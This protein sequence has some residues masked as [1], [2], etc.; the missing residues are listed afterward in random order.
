MPIRKPRKEHW[1]T[2]LSATWWPISKRLRK[3]RVTLLTS[4]GVGRLRIL[5]LMTSLKPSRRKGEMADLTPQQAIEKLRALP[6]DKQRQVLT[7]LSPEE[8]K[9]IIAQLQGGTSSAAAAAP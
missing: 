9:G 5:M 4:T 2:I 6:E 3:L 8:R 1:A 7:R